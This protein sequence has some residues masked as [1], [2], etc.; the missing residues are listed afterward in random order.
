MLHKMFPVAPDFY[1]LLNQQCDLAVA[2]TG[3]LVDFMEN[4]DLEIALEIRELEHEGD[5]LKARNLKALNE[6]FATVI[7]RDDIDRGI[8]SIDEILNYSKS[9]VREVEALQVTPDSPMAEMA[10]RIHEGTGSLRRGYVL[11]GSDAEK[12]ESEALAAHKA[13]RHTEKIYR[14]ALSQLFDDDRLVT[15]VRNAGADGALTAAREVVR[16]F[17]RREVYRHLSNAADRVAL[18]SEYLLDSIV[19]AI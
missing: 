9:T 6:S 8:R 19:K 18:A 5:R 14:Q 16:M 13:E 1:A 3:K 4:G 10:K 7:D 12:A 17:R 11:L 15:R 2:S